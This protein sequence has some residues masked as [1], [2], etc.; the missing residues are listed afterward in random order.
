M[1]LSI[2]PGRCIG[3]TDLNR[4]ETP[5]A[6]LACVSLAFLPPVACVLQQYLENHWLEHTPF[7]LSDHFLADPTLEVSVGL[8]VTHRFGDA[9]IFKTT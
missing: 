2:L 5:H 1:T 9:L 8:S 3:D 7:I 4:M 6:P